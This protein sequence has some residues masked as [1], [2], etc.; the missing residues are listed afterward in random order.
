[1]LSKLSHLLNVRSC[2]SLLQSVI[3]I[4]DYLAYAVD[5]KWKWLSLIDHET[6][7]K[8][9]YFYRKCL[10][11]QIKP[12][13]GLSFTFKYQDIS[14]QG[15][16]LAFSNKGYYNLVKLSSFLNEKSQEQG[17]SLQALLKY[18]PGNHLIIDPFVYQEDGSIQEEQA[19]FNYLD[20]LTEVIKQEDQQ[21]LYIAVNN[22]N[23]HYFTEQQKNSYQKHLI[24]FQPVLYFYPQDSIYLSKLYQIAK[25]T[26]QPVKHFSMTFPQEVQFYVDNMQ[27]LAESINLIIKKH[28]FAENLA[29]AKSTLNQD[30][31]LVLK[32]MA[33][34]RLKKRL[35]SQ[36]LPTPYQLRLEK[37]LAVISDRHFANYFLLIEDYV[38]QALQN[39]IYIG[40]GRGSA[41]GSLVSYAL[42]ITQIDP[43]K[44]GLLF[45]RFLNL[46]RKDLPD[47]DIDIEDTKRD[48]FIKDYLIKTYGEDKV[49]YITT[50]Q[51]YGLK[52]A[53][54]DLARLEPDLHLS[55]VNKICKLVNPK[56]NFNYKKALKDNK[57][58]QSYAYKYP[59][60]FEQARYFLKIP[61]HVGTHAAGIIM[62]QQPL[63]T[64][65]PCAIVNEGATESFLKSQYAM[66]DLADLNIVKLDLLALKTL[67]ILHTIV[68]KINQ[69]ASKKNPLLLE[70]I[71]LNDATT[72]SL[73]QKGETKGIFQLESWGMTNLLTKMRPVSFQDV[74]V[75]SALFRP[76][77]QDH[78]DDYVDRKTQKKAVHY[79]NH[80]LANILQETY[81]VLLFQEQVMLIAQAVAQ[82][83][84][85]K[86]DLLRKAI[87]KKDPVLMQEIKDAFYSQAS[88]NGYDSTQ[89]KTIWTLIAKFAGYGFNKS[90]AVSYGLVSYW[91]AYLKTHYFGHFVCTMLDS[92]RSDKTKTKNF[93]EE[94]L[95]HGYQLAYPSVQNPT[96][97]YQLHSD[98]KLM[99]PLIGVSKIGNL[100]Y[101]KLKVVYDN[102]PFLDIYDFM[103]R[104]YQAK[105]LKSFPTRA[106]G[107]RSVQPFYLALVYSGALDCFQY[108][109]TTLI[110]SWLKL[111][112]YAA[113]NNED[114]MSKPLLR[115]TTESQLDLE[116]LAQAEKTY[117]GFSIMQNKK[118]SVL[119]KQYQ[120]YHVTSIKE[121]KKSLNNHTNTAKKS[122]VILGMIDNLRVFKDKKNNDMARFTLKEDDRTISV[123]VF[124]GQYQSY[125]A[126]LQGQHLAL[127]QIKMSFFND[128]WS[129]HLEKLKIIE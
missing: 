22:N 101:H 106:S 87:S 95:A 62:T 72:F 125:Q 69:T 28:S 112:Q 114:S 19:C 98:K 126:K 38:N 51:T 8:H 83:S 7:Y 21:F 46:E 117:L 65:V 58:L 119:K 52:S 93:L 61:S 50:F 85:S 122:F 79:L 128:T 71:P 86:A 37:E 56:L 90:H 29:R 100:Y 13:L 70:Q 53:L 42:N 78:I 92:F 47:I 34:A 43:L 1:M 35:K 118:L 5:Q 82:F 120:A 81:G 23:L 16:L 115:K 49:A 124:A 4:D 33:F 12:L 40:P 96:S 89:I 107:D 68:D 97:L 57:Q 44:Y 32:N 64:L 123:V 129:A 27:A 26:N 127:V 24:W 109:R 84:L 111:W 45:E 99:I 116:E 41:A 11:H 60:L 66:D 113:L 108:R 104:L 3:K 94:A 6:M 55:E 2:Y 105:V 77:P 15:S 91:L 103:H 9:Y 31:N 75:T 25:T 14:F 39:N 63:N 59:V 121:V 102:K 76:G 30:E 74:Y 54:R 20:Q 67:S 73:L 110:R 88:K 48:L 36:T 18:L 80:T 10:A 17:L